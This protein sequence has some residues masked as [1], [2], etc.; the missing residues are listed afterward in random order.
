MLALLHGQSELGIDVSAVSEVVGI[1]EAAS[2][3]NVKLDLPPEFSEWVALFA[4]E[5]GS[6]NNFVSERSGVLIVPAE[7]Y[8]NIAIIGIAK[9]RI[10]TNLPPSGLHR[11][12]AII[13]RDDLLE[14]S[15]EIE[16]MKLYFLA[17]PKHNKI[18]QL[19]DLPSSKIE[20]MTISS[21]VAIKKLKLNQTVTIPA[22]PPPPS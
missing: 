22:A 5:A 20:D 15:I 3:T 2:C 13:Q 16:T 9:H 17:S 1:Q 14:A 6:P 21:I 18:E 12:H 19:A 11:Y 7:I 10:V 4:I 8:D